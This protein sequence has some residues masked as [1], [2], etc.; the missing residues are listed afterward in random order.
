MFPFRHIVKLDE[1]SWLW[2]S[3]TERPNRFDGA[4]E[5]GVDYF[6]GEYSIHGREVGFAEK[7]VAVL[8]VA[9][10]E[11]GF[12]CATPSFGSFFRMNEFLSILL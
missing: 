3:Y 6:Q 8:R 7:S 1:E 10:S 4:N 5:L 11:S 12:S 9:D 2:E